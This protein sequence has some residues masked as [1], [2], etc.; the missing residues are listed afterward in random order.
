[1]RTL[2]WLVFTVYS[3]TLTT[4]PNPSHTITRKSEITVRTLGPVWGLCGDQWSQQG[5]C[6]CQ[7]WSP[8]GNARTYTHT[9]HALHPFHQPFTLCTCFC[10]CVCRVIACM[11]V[12]ALRHAVI[13]PCYRHSCGLE[14]GIVWL[15]FSH[16]LFLLC[17]K[18]GMTSSPKH[19]ILQSNRMPAC[20][21]CV[22]SLFLFV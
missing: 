10:L 5:L 6:F 16:I 7:K 18:C 22:T 4:W 13:F 11:C 20:R 19:S 8:I 17:L 21:I 3:L 14:A 1:M 2:H 9:P 15:S 12:R